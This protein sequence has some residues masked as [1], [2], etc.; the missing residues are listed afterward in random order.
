[1]PNLLRWSAPIQ[2]SAEDRPPPPR[3]DK[4]DKGAR[5][6]GGVPR[7]LRGGTP[8]GS[9]RRESQSSQGRV[10]LIRG[11]RL[12]VPRVRRPRVQR[13]RKRNG[14]A[15]RTPVRWGTIPHRETRGFLRAGPCGTPSTS[16][17]AIS[18]MILTQ[19]SP[20]IRRMS[21]SGTSC[22]AGGA[23]R[24]RQRDFERFI[25]KTLRW[26]QPYDKQFFDNQWRDVL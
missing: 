11:R 14:R 10:P 2:E 26:Y 18:S 25:L 23:T 9:W 5:F 22:K 21:A 1:M 3:A 4:G 24:A 19:A 16:S 7:V 13:V 15:E 12:R 20:V 6:Q 17:T 8:K